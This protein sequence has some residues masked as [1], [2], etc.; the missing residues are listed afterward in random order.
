[1]GYPVAILQPIDAQSRRLVH[2]KSWR[3]L[4]QDFINHTV[5][6]RRP[7]A[8]T[9]CTYKSCISALT[10]VETL[11]NAIRAVCR[12]YP[13]TACNPQSWRDKGKTDRCT[14][15]DSDVAICRSSFCVCVCAWQRHTEIPFYSYYCCDVF[16]GYA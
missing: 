13:F 2:S 16:T 5:E 15:T 8:R 12:L 6:H 4:N 3:R 9:V 1:M 10:M 7:R 11:C 14:D